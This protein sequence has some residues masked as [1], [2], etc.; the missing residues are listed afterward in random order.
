M[1]EWICTNRLGSFAMGTAKRTP[2]RKYHGLFILRRAGLLEPLHV[3]SDVNEVLIDAGRTFELASYH[4]GNADFPRGFEHQVAFSA[5]PCPTWEYQCG[6]ARVSR[7][8]E[9]VAERNELR[10]H[11]RVS[12]AGQGAELR[13]SPLLSARG[14]H[15]L[16][17]ENPFLDGRVRDANPGVGFRLYRD[18]PE[19][20]M[21]CEP[22]ADFEPKGF[23]NRSV[24]YPEEERRGYPDKEDLFCPGYFSLKFD[25]ELECTLHLQLP[26]DAPELDEEEWDGPHFIEP[27]IQEFADALAQAAQQF[28]YIEQASG[29]PGVIA[30]YP[31]FGEWGRDTLIALPGL[32]LETARTRTAARIIDRFARSRRDGLIPNLVGEDADHSDWFSVDASLWFIRAVQ[33]IHTQ[34]GKAVAGRWFEAV[35][36]ILETLRSGKVPGV[37]VDESGLLGVDLRPRPGSWMDAQINGQAVTPRA[38]FAVELNALFYNAVQYALRLAR[39]AGK[40]AFLETWKPIKEKLAGAFIEKFWLEDEGYLADCTDGVTPDKS[41]RPNQLFAA[42]LP[43]RPIDKKQARRM[44][45]NA[46]HYLR[47]PVGLRSLAPDDPKYRG[48]LVGEQE[49]RDLAYHNGTVW[50]W[51]LGAYVD[52]VAFAEGEDAATE[53]VSELARSFKKQLKEGC[54]GQVAEV[55]DGDE[56]HN[57][58]GA[59]AQAWSIAELLRVTYRYGHRNDERSR[60]M[61]AVRQESSGAVTA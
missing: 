30:G 46:R 13:L 44:L 55:F 33:D 39:Q 47:T 20:T 31:W 10:I 57:E 12:G 50:S 61:K 29:E 9:L 2:E 58:R 18:F 34:E 43:F 11:Y 8:L 36:E 54:I 49:E 32:L 14:M 40:S 17:H 59:P 24:R 26:G 6:D 15:Q 19:F 51:L 48:Q 41:L 3:L 7:R 35:F 22:P 16:G 1:H 53:E 27:G 60:R 23:W 45:E 21:R 42:S 56:P 28:V 25:G 37:W 52:A 4:Y 5:D 38:P